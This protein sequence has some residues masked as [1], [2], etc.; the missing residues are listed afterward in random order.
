MA[1]PL[2]TA[3]LT[4]LAAFV[5]HQIQAQD[6]PLDF[7]HK[8]APILKEHCGD[9]HTGEKKK[10]GF[11][12][13]THPDWLHGSENGPVF[14]AQNPS[15]SKALEVIASSDPDTVMPPLAKDKKRPTA[16]QIA[17]LKNWPRQQ[18]LWA[19]SGSGSAPRL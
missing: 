5:A 9:C 15:H 1:V 7:A 17:V 6:A 13:N 10:G 8:V 14:D 4:A 12:M 3:V 18:N 11:S 19:S 2:R 16:E